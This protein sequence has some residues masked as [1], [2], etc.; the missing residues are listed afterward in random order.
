MT[1]PVQATFDDV[2]PTAPDEYV[3]QIERCVQAV[4][5][6]RTWQLSEL[7]AEAGIVEPAGYEKLNGSVTR[8]LKQAGVIE[9]VGYAPSLRATTSGSAVRTWRRR[10]AGERVAS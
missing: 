1:P 4:P 10:A 7:I 5:C 8:R 9:A 3:A 6:W 2:L